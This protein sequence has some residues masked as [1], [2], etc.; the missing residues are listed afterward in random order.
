LIVVIIEAITLSSRIAAALTRQM[1]YRVRPQCDAAVRLAASGGAPFVDWRAPAAVA[2]VVAYLA[3]M[4][5]VMLLWPQNTAMSKLDRSF[6]T[7]EKNV[8]SLRHGENVRL[9][10]LPAVLLHRS[11]SRLLANAPA[12]HRIFSPTEIL[13]WWCG[14]ETG[15]AML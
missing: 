14:T 4:H 13:C 12:T 11:A 3:D 15:A 8:L 9:A 5:V 6:S 7:V 1:F 10:L 2:G